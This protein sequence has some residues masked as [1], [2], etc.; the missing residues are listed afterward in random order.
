[1]FHAHRHLVPLLLISTYLSVPLALHAA[2]L[3]HGRIL[4]AHSTDAESGRCRDGFIF[5]RMSDDGSPSLFQDLHTTAENEALVASL[6][7]EVVTIE[8]TASENALSVI[9][10]LESDPEVSAVTHQTLP[11]AIGEQSTLVLL[12]HFP[13]AQIDPA[14]GDK[15]EL[16]QM[17]FG[18]FQSGSINHRYLMAS[19]GLAWLSGKTVGPFI[20]NRFSPSAPSDG[21]AYGYWTQQALAQ[22]QAQGINASDYRRRVTIFP[23]G[24]SCG[25]KGLGI[26]GARSNSDAWIRF[27]SSQ[28]LGHEYGHNLGLR[29][30]LSASGGEDGSTI[31]GSSCQSSAGVNGAHKY[32]SE[33]LPGSETINVTRSGTYAIQGLMYDGFSRPEAQVLRMYRGPGSESFLYVSYRAFWGEDRLLDTAVQRSVQINSSTP[34]RASDLQGEPSLLSTLALGSAY[35]DPV[36]GAQIR[37]QSRTDE[38][39]TIQVTIPSSWNY[40][41]SGTVSLGGAPLADV[42]MITDNLGESV[43]TDATGRYAFTGLRTG[44][45]YRL[46]PRKAGYRFTPASVQGTLA[47]S[48]SQNFTAEFV[49]SA[50]LRGRI[51]SNGAPVPNVRM[52]AGELSP[53]VLSDS[54]GEFS[55][56]PLSNG[57][58]YSITPILAGYNFSPE[59]I[60]G[61]VNGASSANFLAT[62]RRWTVTGRVHRNGSGAPGNIVSL[63]RATGNMEAAIFQEAET[64][65][66]GYYRIDNVPD[67]SVANIV[68]RFPSGT[69][70]YSPYPA[71]LTIN[72]NKQQNFEIVSSNFELSGLV[73]DPANIPMSGVTVSSTLLGNSIT[74]SDGR[75]IFNNAPQRVYVVITPK[76]RGYLFSPP[77]ERLP[78]FNT[79]SWPRFVGTP[80]SCRADYDD[81]GDVSTFDLISFVGDWVSKEGD[82][83]VDRN[84]VVNDADMWAM[85]ISWFGGC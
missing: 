27:A 13:D 5:E 43:Q 58:A 73:V 15:E 36:S 16:N 52:Y 60:T 84:N 6:V 50:E 76:K 39:A 81:S 67:N 14:Y 7:N 59:S 85:A 56:G 19:S 29:H 2:D 47:S 20:V 54:N 25:W 18:D 34:N 51:L 63:S 45:L 80:N 26:T 8:A 17:V 77:F 37:F 38:V 57:T 68:V 49:G 65:E 24:V 70:P 46:A 23:H 28:V 64:D 75:F 3:F 31:M 40:S 53:P 71:R 21:C 62:A 78:I 10:V 74:G 9:R 55:F 69:S 33:W 22:A 32:G 83:D 4:A 11:P 44:V 1:M 82:A 61:V 41:V 66:Q 72:E 79:T 30:S 42:A 12:V 35:T 48:L